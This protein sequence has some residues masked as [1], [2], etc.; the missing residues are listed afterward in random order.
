M[1][2]ATDSDVSPSATARA[3]NTFSPSRDV[4]ATES[5]PRGRR[6]YVGKSPSP[7]TLYSNTASFLL[8]PRYNVTVATLVAATGT[9]ANRTSTRYRIVHVNLAGV[10]SGAPSPPNPR[11]RKLCS[12]S[13][14]FW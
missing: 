7:L 1:A 5:C 8:E 13:A 6:A 3:W 4:T 10:A 9:T 2:R 11:T 14:K 12:P